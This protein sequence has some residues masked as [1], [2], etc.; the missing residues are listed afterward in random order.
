MQ[1]EQ[2]SLEE[3][4]KRSVFSNPVTELKPDKGVNEKDLQRA[5]LSKQENRIGVER[6]GKHVQQ[7]FCETVKESKELIGELA[8]GIKDMIEKMRERR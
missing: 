3:S 7:E 1:K 6:F 4:K 2:L 5:F 8:D